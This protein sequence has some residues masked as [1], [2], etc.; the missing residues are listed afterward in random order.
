[1]L[2]EAVHTVFESP[3]L[4][5]VLLFS[6]GRY[7][8]SILEDHFALFLEDSWHRGGKAITAYFRQCLKV[9]KLRLGELILTE[10]RQLRIISILS[11]Q[12]Q[13]L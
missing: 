10:E 9:S 5:V 8:G 1:M 7:P 6:S 2:Q 3:A 4:W 11:P 12:L 13:A